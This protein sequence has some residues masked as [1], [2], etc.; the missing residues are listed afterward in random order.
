MGGIGLEVVSSSW[1]DTLRCGAVKFSACYYT[2]RQFLLFFLN[3]VL[4]CRRTRSRRSRQR[5]SASRIGRLDW[6]GGTPSC[7]TN[8]SNGLR[9]NGPTYK[10][11]RR[12]Y[13]VHCNVDC[14]RVCCAFL[15]ISAAWY[16]VDVCAPFLF[17][18][19]HRQCRCSSTGACAYFVKNSLAQRYTLCI[20]R[21]LRYEY[22]FWQWS[23]RPNGSALYAAYDWLRWLSSVQPLVWLGCAP[24]TSAQN[25]I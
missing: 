8:S 22:I 7:S 25:R 13:N 9:G 18:L 10:S 14:V 1:V 20:L 11:N 3:R 4:C 17:L 21:T 23:D 24:D 6:G 12:P 5:V 15:C 16:T 2:N 19:L